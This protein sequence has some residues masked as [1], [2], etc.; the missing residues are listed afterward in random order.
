MGKVTETIV[1]T[2]KEVTKETVKFGGK[3][4]TGAC[5]GIRYLFGK[6]FPKK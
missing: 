1:I 6:P 2:T 3:I 5:S 4:I